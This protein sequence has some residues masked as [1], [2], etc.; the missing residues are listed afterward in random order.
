VP[1]SLVGPP[2]NAIVTSTD[3]LVPKV[4][5]AGAGTPSAAVN[6]ISESASLSLT[7]AS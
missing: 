1:P 7:P 2:E 4:N 3:P 5:C 6:P